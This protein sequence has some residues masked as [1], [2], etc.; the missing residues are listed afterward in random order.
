[1]MGAEVGAKQKQI[2]YTVEECPKCG[3][4]NKRLF[5]LGDFIIKEVGKCPRCGTTMSISA[6]YAEAPPKS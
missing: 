2:I 6:I 5:T 4:K 1:L 3:L